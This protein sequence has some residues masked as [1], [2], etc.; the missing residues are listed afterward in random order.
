MYTHCTNSYLH[1]T[2]SQIEET[3]AAFS[4]WLGASEYELLQGRTPAGQSKVIISASHTSTR[5]YPFTVLSLEWAPLRVVR[6]KEAELQQSLLAAKHQRSAR[7]HKR[8][9]RGGVFSSLFGGGVQGGSG[10]G[11]RGRDRR[12]S[13]ADPGS[14]P[15][16]WVPTGGCLTPDDRNTPRLQ[17]K[18]G[19]C[20]CPVSPSWLHAMGA[21]DQD[22][23]FNDV[24][25]PS[26]GSG[27][28]SGT[29]TG[30]GTETE[31]ET[32]TSDYRA[33]DHW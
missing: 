4:R 26:P 32:E 13:A 27:S 31:T 29:G 20:K 3:S 15:W 30:T 7:Q 22:P 11:R 17:V 1:C 18:D 8:S 14:E 2:R 19:A 5:S 10:Q 33:L 21:E 24:R 25:G 16:V 9:S 28:R 6:G 23:N 12:A